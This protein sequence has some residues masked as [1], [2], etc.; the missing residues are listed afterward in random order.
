MGGLAILTSSRRGNGPSSSYYAKTGRTK[1]LLTASGSRWTAPSTTSRRYS[2][3]LGVSTREEAAA[4]SGDVTGKRSTFTRIAIALGGSAVVAAAVVG[5]VGAS[6]GSLR[7]R[8]TRHG[9]T[10]ARMDPSDAGPLATRGAIGR[11]CRHWASG[12]G[13]SR[14][15]EECVTRRH[16]GRLHHLVWYA[17]EVRWDAQERAI[18]YTRASNPSATPVIFREGDIVD[19]EGAEPWDGLGYVV[20]PAESCEGQGLLVMDIAVT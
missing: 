12:S 8:R 2:R 15:S 17:D 10:V 3:K 14:S 20:P 16:I 4:W 18:T 6:L 9:R 1:R 5:L 13:P 11:S 7:V 19:I